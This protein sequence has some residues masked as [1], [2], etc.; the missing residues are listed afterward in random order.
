[1]KQCPIHPTKLQRT[2]LPL[3]ALLVGATLLFA[4]CSDQKAPAKTTASANATS[5]AT[6]PAAGT[7]KATEQ[8][9]KP[10]PVATDAKLDARNAATDVKPSANAAEKAAAAAAVNGRA[11]PGDAVP[12]N[13][14]PTR[15]ATNP[16]AS[17]QA[18]REAA[19]K[20]AA[21]KDAAAATPAPT[22]PPPRLDVDATDHDFGTAIQGEHLTHTFKLK[23]SGPGDLVIQNAKPTCGC[24]LAKLETVKK[25]GSTQE[26]KYGD[27]LPPGT[28]LNL[29]AQ[30]DTKNKTNIASSKINI[31][32]ND[33][34]SL[35][36]L[37][38][39]AKVET[40]FVITPNALQF[41]EMSVADTA[42]QSFQVSGKKPT[43]FMLSLENK[44]LPDGMKIDLTPVEPDAAGK[45]TRW[46]VKVKLGPNCKEGNLGFPI[47]LKSD[48]AVAG[49]AVENGVTPTY[50]ANVM[51]TARI[52]GLISWDP[53]YLSF[54]LVRPGQVVARSLTV[55]SF[56][57][58]FTFKDPKVKIVGPSDQKPEF[59]YG[60]S[61]AYTVKT[62]EDAKSL[63][64][65]LTLNGLP[66]TVD[67][68]FQ[69][70]VILETGHPARPEVPVLFSGV[71]RPG[72][73]AA[74]PPAPENKPAGG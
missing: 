61:F 36:T 48:E 45:A 38:L 59:Q 10:A 55:K 31:Y 30:L 24:T 41:N 27:P 71:C 23:S 50:G 21:Q 60:D 26:Y 67:G 58:N 63:T 66:E 44:Q 35:V 51:V 13:T 19:Q 16:A 1:M 3:T 8:P 57:P 37:G 43:G 47:Q 33:P 17:S 2:Q 69:G 25:D 4:S 29:T 52:Q 9:V 20:D 65:E 56:D 46:D 32:C 64:I 18:Q 54:G 49:A 28:D 22:G 40:Y 74:T 34:R 5:N 72:V 68:S 11:V 62:S 53:Q 15:D 70:R 6:K 42:E 73:K 39:N 14:P 12:T 7:N